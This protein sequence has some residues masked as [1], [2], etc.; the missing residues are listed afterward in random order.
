MEIS[1]PEKKRLLTMGISDLNTIEV[2]QLLQKYE[3]PWVVL[4]QWR[5]IVK[6]QAADA[7]DVNRDEE[8]EKTESA[9]DT[10]IEDASYEPS[11]SGNEER[12]LVLR[13][14]LPL[15][16]S[17]K[18]KPDQESLRTLP[19]RDRAA[20]SDRTRQRNAVE[21]TKGE[22]ESVRSIESLR[23]RRLAAVLSG[24]GQGIAK[25]DVSVIPR[26]NER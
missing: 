8:S 13:G 14:P 26:R 9:S 19:D 15:Q 25:F 10:V 17:S 22:Q 6:G 16:T 24:V 4:K 20:R 3:I 5:D 21:V 23:K 1:K 18:K 12:Q 7:S 11:S 2:R